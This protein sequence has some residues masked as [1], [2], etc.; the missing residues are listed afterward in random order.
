MK[1][2]FDLL[3]SIGIIIT[4]LPAVILLYNSIKRKH[5][6]EYKNKKL[7]KLFSAILLLGTLTIL[8]GSFIEPNILVTN[9]Q[10]IH[11]SGIDSPI[12]I[13][14]IADFQVGP[15]KKTAHIE[16]VVNRIISLEP[17]IV[18]IGGD[19]VDNGGT[20]N[21]ETIYLEPLKKLVSAG[22]P[23]YSI[24]GN[25]EYGV[26]SELSMKDRKKRLPNVSTQVQESMEAL[27]IRYLINELEEISV[28]NQ[29]FYIFGGDSLLFDNALSFDA[30]QKREKT[31]P[32][33]ALIHNPAAAWETS[34]QNVDLML[35]GHT[36][37]G[38][39]RLP[40]LGPIGRADKIIPLDWYQ[41][42]KKVDEMQLFVTSGTGETGAR[43]RLFNPPEVVLIT[44]K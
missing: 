11:L 31:I 20:P 3:I 8:Y 29:S 4:A 24:H 6:W 39:I 21:D 16:K 28:R 33:I 13:A 23:V 30:L 38:Q 10:S 14:F 41:G 25:H 42:L 34:K 27:G 32:T 2:Y 40:F 26:G 19:Q 1:L 15:Y 12:R 9:N 18:L 36:H 37:G 44:L 43:S 5:S 7:T 35:S 17:D 22:L